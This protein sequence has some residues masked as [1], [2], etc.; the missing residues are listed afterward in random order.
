MREKIIQNKVSKSVSLAELKPT[1]EKIFTI[2]KNQNRVPLGIGYDGTLN[3]L[4]A[5]LKANGHDVD[6][7]SVKSILNEINSSIKTKYPDKFQGTDEHKKLYPE[8]YEE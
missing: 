5:E 2:Y 8:L 1:V 6:G 7:N 4:V 3:Q